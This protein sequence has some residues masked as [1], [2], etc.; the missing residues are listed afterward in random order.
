MGRNCGYLAAETTRRYRAWLD[1]QEWLPEIGLSREAWEVHA[2]YL[3]EL[4]IDIAAEAARLRGV[5]SAIGNVNI[6]ISEGAGVNEIVAEL[7]K[8]GVE[9][10]T[11]AFGH[12]KLD[13]INP[14]EWFARAFADAIGAEKVMVQRSGY[15]SRSAASNAEDLELIA[16]TCAL[17]VT[18]ALEGRPGVIGMDEENG[19]ELTTIAFD[20]IAGHKPFNPNQ[21]WFQEML[22]EIGQ[23]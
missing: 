18:S 10:P 9:I 3:P 16:R 19:G 11:D 17:A 8:E 15:F 2:L 22:R 14:G 4:P 5:M 7:Q 13:K 6:F 23:S 20:R 21:D 12:I 1:E